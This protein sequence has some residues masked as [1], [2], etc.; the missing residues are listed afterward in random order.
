MMMK[1][2]AA[3][4]LIAGCMAL[5]ACSAGGEL[6]VRDGPQMKHPVYDV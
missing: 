6:P 5:S 3:A 4:A 1:I 2:V